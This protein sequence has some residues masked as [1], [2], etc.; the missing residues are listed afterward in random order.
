MEWLDTGTLMERINF[1]SEQLGDASKPGV[2]A[3]VERIAG[4]DTDDAAPEALVERCLDQMGALAASDDTRSALL[5]LAGQEDGA[6]ERNITQMLR[7]AA[8]SREFQ[9]I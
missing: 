2:R 4:D 3:M 8:A 1:A 5:M 7:L 6:T 9:R